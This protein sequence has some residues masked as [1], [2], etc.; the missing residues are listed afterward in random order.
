MMTKR[1]SRNLTLAI[2]A[3]LAATSAVHTAAA[4]GNL[5]RADVLDGGYL[6]AAAEKS[7]EGKCGEGQCGADKASE[8]GKCGEGKCGGNKAS[9]EGK[10]GEGKCGSDKASEEGKCGEGKCGG[11]A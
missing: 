10:C 4:D 6:L 5:F 1:R 3:A 9:E 2:G 7:H 11:A 8:E